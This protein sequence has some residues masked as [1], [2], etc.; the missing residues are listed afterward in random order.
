MLHLHLVIDRVD[1]FRPT[2]DRELEARV[3]QLLL[4]RSD[5]RGYIRIALRLLRRQLVRDIFIFCIVGKLQRQILHL[6]LDL[7]QTQTV[8]QW[9]MQ[10][11]SLVGYMPTTIRIS[12]LVQSP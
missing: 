7:I 12:L 3:V 11:R 5:K 6:R 1:G 2:L 4:Q 10:T 9:S 8:S